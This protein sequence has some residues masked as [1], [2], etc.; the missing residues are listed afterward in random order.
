MRR[1]FNTVVLPL[2]GQRRGGGRDRPAAPRRG[3]RARS[4][5]RRRRSALEEIRRVVT[6]FR[7]LRSGVT[8]DGRTKLKSPSGTLSTAEAISRRHQRARARH[9][10]R[11]RLA[12]ARG[13]RG[14]PDRRGRP[15]PGAGQG[16]LAG[17]PRGGRARARR[18]GRAV[19]R[20]P[21][22]VTH[23]VFGIRHH[24]PGSARSSN[25]RWKSS[26]P[27][28]VLIEGPPEADAL[29]ALAA[30][31]DMAPPVAL[32]TYVPDEP[33]PRRVLPLRPLLARVAR[34]PPRA[35]RTTSPSASW[36]CRP[37]TRWPTAASDEPR[38]GLRAD[39]LARARRGRRPRRPGALVGG[40]RRVPPRGP[41]PSRR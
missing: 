33:A 19:P 17:V 28:T 34:D 10:L 26:Q 23:T 20:L 35:R 41:T 1:R 15:G 36:T 39:P 22:A 38:A 4:S 25:A 2:P 3:R 16:R 29:L 12:D 11:R 24:G 27:D 7:E 31:E 13:P 37:R 8:E 40:R 32:L 14:R 21:R 5:S 18:L 9:P 30:R 6:I